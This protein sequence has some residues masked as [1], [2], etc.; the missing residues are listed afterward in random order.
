[1]KI[2]KK[3]LAVVILVLILPALSL[4]QQITKDSINVLLKRADDK[5]QV[6]P[7]ERIMLLEQALAASR[8]IEYSNGIIRAQQR[9]GKHYNSYGELDIALPALQESIQLADET[10]DSL[11]WAKSN[12]YYAMAYMEDNKESEAIG[13][14]M[15]ALNYFESTHNR[16]W[17][18][19]TI[20]SI[21]SCYIS[22]DKGT[23]G[24]K[25]YQ[26]AYQILDSLEL[27]DRVIPIFNMS[28][29]Y[30]V[31]RQP[32]TALSFIK[33]ALEIYE[34]DEDY[35]GITLAYL[36]MGY[37]YFL[38]D[39]F[40]KSIEFYKTSAEYAKEHGYQTLLATIY[41]ALSQCHEKLGL[42][43]D[44]L[45]FY[46]EYHILQDS[47]V[48]N[49]TKERVSELEIKYK[50]V[51]KDQKL[52]RQQASITQL[53]HQLT[54]DRQQKLLLGGGFFLLLAVGWLIYNKQKSDSAKKSKLHQLEKELIESKLK[55]KELEKE[56]IQDELSYKSKHLTDFAL[57]IAHKNQLAHELVEGLKSLRGMGPNKQEMI[58]KDLSM[59]AITHLR[60]NEELQAFQNNIE[61]LNY[62]FYQ[63][64][65]QQFPQLTK[66]D[67]ILCGLIRLR[68]QTKE[69]ASLRNVSDDAVKMARYRLRKKLGLYPEEDITKFLQHL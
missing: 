1:M 16:E 29:Y 49:E 61:E 26:D 45:S 28:Y 47:I 12:Y 46:K 44:A 35:Y 62:K 11:E 13:Y 55:Q 66:N 18:A 41:N 3:L 6:S 36:N 69:I 39:Q 38:Q 32:K 64:L 7:E 21:G 51:K 42:I 48:T 4:S 43:N 58:I 5:D 57:E 14:L 31:N 27:P 68:L 10:G 2:Y 37:A 54:I 17:Y 25:Y 33:E 24:V 34:S 20:V 56:R 59:L 67:V 40:D 53:K 19:Y 30:L 23:K 50:T 65:E 52:E 63:K 15:A 22:M 9:I 60:P 8:S